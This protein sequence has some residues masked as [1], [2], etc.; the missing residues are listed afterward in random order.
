MSAEVDLPVELDSTVKGHYKVIHDYNAELSQ[1]K[2]DAEE[3]ERDVKLL[4]TKLDAA[5]RANY[6]L[7]SALINYLDAVGQLAELVPGTK[8]TYFECPLLAPENLDGVHR[9]ENLDKAGKA[10]RKALNLVK[11][12]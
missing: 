2:V 5:E 4:T 3:Y 7:Q 10:A 9:W 6:I 11:G 12:D 8:Q 1:C